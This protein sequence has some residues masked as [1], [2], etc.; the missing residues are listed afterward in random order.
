MTQSRRRRAVLAKRVK[1]GAELLDKHRPGWAD[2]IDTPA[3]QIE[4]ADRCVLGQVFGDY[5]GGLDKLEDV[6][7]EWNGKTGAYDRDPADFGFCEP[8]IDE[9]EQM[10]YTAERYHAELRQLWTAEV[11]KRMPQEQVEVRL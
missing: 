6:I 5:A 8:A 4:S 1:A 9:L 3:L 7:W 2:Q 11:L 10:E